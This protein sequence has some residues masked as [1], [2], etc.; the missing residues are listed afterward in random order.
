MRLPPNSCGW[1]MYAGQSA[2][3]LQRASLS[4]LL[5]WASRTP[6]VLTSPL[7]VPFFVLLLQCSYPY[8]HLCPS[9]QVSA[10]W[11]YRAHADRRQQADGG[12]HCRGVRDHQQ[13]GRR[14]GGWRS[15]G[16]ARVSR[17]VGRPDSR[18]AAQAPGALAYLE[19]EASRP[20][21][22]SGL[23]SRFWL[24]LLPTTS[25]GSCKL[26]GRRARSLR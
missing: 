23:P 6:S 13:P 21:S 1:L 14:T 19:A 3:R 9:S 5:C 2:R 4:C 18:P 26:Y 7:P 25:S 8:L 10:G 22:S 15:H 12:A 20:D 11:R 16:G 17:S 24:A